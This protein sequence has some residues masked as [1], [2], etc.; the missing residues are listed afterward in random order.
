MVRAPRQVYPQPMAPRL[1]PAALIVLSVGT[2]SGCSAQSPA[3]PAPA[4]EPA[5]SDPGAEAPCIV[6]E[7][8]LDVPDYASQSEDYLVGLGIPI[9]DFEMTG[10]GTMTFTESGLVAGVIDLSITG[11]LV[12]GDTRVPVDQ[13]S[14]YEGSGDWSQ[15]DDPTTIDLANWANVPV[16]DTAADPGAF[17]DPDAPVP[18]IDFTDIPAVTAEC[19]ADTLWLQ[20]PGAPMSSLWH[21]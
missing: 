2:V 16:P 15:P 8:Q 1:L 18:A 11:T 19:T 6:G 9:E 21:R 14:A 7:W 4:P 13:R 5:A 17:D 3:E 12:A 20:A 10:N